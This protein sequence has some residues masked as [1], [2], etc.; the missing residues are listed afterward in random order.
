MSINSPTSSQKAYQWAK[1]KGILS[2]RG[3]YIKFKDSKTQKSTGEHIIKFLDDHSVDGTNFK[4]RKPEKK[5]RY[6]FEEDGVE[7]IY[8]TALLSLVKDRDGNVEKNDDGSDKVKLSIFVEQMQDF[9]RGDILRANYTPNKGSLGGFTKL[10]K[11]NMEDGDEEELEEGEDPE[12]RKVVPK[13]GA[14]DEDAEEFFNGH[15]PGTD[16]GEINPDNIPF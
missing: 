2:E 3:N 16:D 1:E 15:V 9:E 8:E 5:M 12:I 4:T 13:A 11:M 10:D 6:T 7:K 14:I